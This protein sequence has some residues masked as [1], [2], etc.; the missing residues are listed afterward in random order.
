MDRDHVHGYPLNLPFDYAYDLGCAIANSSKIRNV[1]DKASITEHIEVL[2]RW[3]GAGNQ[4]V[5]KTP[6]VLAYDSEFTRVIA[7][8]SSVGDQHKNQFAHF[9][10]LLHRPANRE[11]Q[12]VDDLA[13]KLQA[14]S[15]RSSSLPRGKTAVDVTADY[16]RPLYQYI[17][18]ILANTYG[19][20]FLASQTLSY[21]ITVPALWSDRS[22][23]LT[24]RAASEAG[25]N[26]KVVLV[27]EPEAA[28]LYCATICDEVDLR[29][30]SKFLGNLGAQG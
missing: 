2:K 28:A 15:I 25:F 27:T 17:Q 19:E 8:G 5:E 22:K 21:V 4:A 18:Q 7:W 20:K 23:A 14:T 11:S 9:K 24:Q 10:L 1:S 26:G 30:G 6:S 16:L 13:W 12:S 29:V 3:P